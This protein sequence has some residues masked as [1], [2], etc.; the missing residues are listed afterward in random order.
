MLHFKL[1]FNQLNFL[2]SMEV[3]L[4]A[5]QVCNQKLYSKKNVIKVNSF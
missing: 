1:H 3:R 4:H 2:Q 5:P